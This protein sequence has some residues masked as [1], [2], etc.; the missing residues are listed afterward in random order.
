MTK[1]YVNLSFIYAI[2]GL[3]AGAFY[4]EF[5][6]Y[7]GYTARTRM[8]LVHPHFLVLGAFMFMIIALFSMNLKLENE[9]TFKTFFLSYNIGV[10]ITAAM[11]FLRGLTEVMDWGD[12][13]ALDASI[14][15]I[16]GVG[17]IVLTVGFVFMYITLK[18]AI[19]NRARN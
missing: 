17:H 19:D 2:I 9:K 6:K 8:A 16:A 14:S 11:L 4:R 15:G 13:K 5:T 1:K 3:V 12:N 7:I 18:R 10:V